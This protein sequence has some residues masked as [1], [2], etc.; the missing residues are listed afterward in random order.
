[1]R[2]IKPKPK[3]YETNNLRFFFLSGLF[4]T[5]RAPLSVRV[6]N[7]NNSGT[8]SEYSLPPSYRARN[9]LLR[10]ATTASG[11]INN[12]GNSR[13]Q[14]QHH[15]S[16]NQSDVSPNN[17]GNSS[18]LQSVNEV[19]KSGVSEETKAIISLA[20]QRHQKQ[21]EEEQRQQQQQ[22][23][24]QQQQPQ[25]NSI[26]L[27][28]SHDISNSSLNTIITIDDNSADNGKIRKVCNVV[29]NSSWRSTTSGYSNVL[30]PTL[31]VKG[32]TI[33]MGAVTV[34]TTEPTTMT[35][36]S[37][38]STPPPI[39]TTTTTPTTVMPACVINSPSKLFT[40][41][42]NVNDIDRIFL[43]STPTL[44]NPVIKNN[45]SVN[46]NDDYMQNDLVTIVTISGCTNTESSTG[47]MDILAHL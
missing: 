21:Q 24:H 47:E 30:I 5:F 7:G 22:N 46:N 18:I 34:T 9:N 36:K 17:T 43:S 23:E 10:L 32:P 19:S 20:N 37:K 35:T 27:D 41:K 3:T 1:M 14:Q 29:G 45:I 2:C 6:N 42:T 25:R 40:T 16:H 13:P 8:G 33:S 11:M 28:T 38:L 39:S 15:Y 12:N 44:T 31:V 4:S 26:L